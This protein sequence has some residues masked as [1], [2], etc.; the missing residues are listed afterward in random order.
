MNGGVRQSGLDKREFP[1]ILYLEN[2][3]NLVEA[4]VNTAVSQDYEDFVV[5]GN[6]AYVTRNCVMAVLIL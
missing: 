4:A 1:L 6:W 5:P 2:P 3:H